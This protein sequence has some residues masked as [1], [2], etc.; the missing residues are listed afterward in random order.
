MVEQFFGLHPLADI[1]ND[2]EQAR[3]VLI[4]ERR[5]VGLDMER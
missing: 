4:N 2:T 1:P 5:P 3:P